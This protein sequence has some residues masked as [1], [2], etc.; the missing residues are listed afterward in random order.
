LLL[1]ARIQMILVAIVYVVVGIFHIYELLFLNC[2]LLE[3]AVIDKCN[4]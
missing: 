1:M 4:L 3:F 2:F